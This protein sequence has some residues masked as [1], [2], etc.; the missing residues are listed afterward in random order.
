M[1]IRNFLFFFLIFISCSDQKATLPARLLTLER[2]QEIQEHIF[3]SGQSKIT[4]VYAEIKTTPTSEVL[5][6]NTIS[7]L[8]EHMKRVDSVT[9]EAVHALEKMKFG[10]LPVSIQ[11]KALIE[12]KSWRKEDKV[13]FTRIDLERINQE[14]EAFFLEKKQALDAKEL[15]KIMQD[16]QFQL[17]FQT[18]AYREYR[19]EK[20]FHFS[21]PK[22]P[23]VASKE[24]YVKQ[25]HAH[26]AQSSID[27]KED[28][29]CLTD[30]YVM[31][32]IPTWKMKSLS[33]EDWFEKQL[34]DLDALGEIQLLTNLQIQL[35]NAR[36]LAL[37]QIS[38]KLLI[39]G[40]GFDSI[41]PMV[42]GQA[43][44]KEGEKAEIQVRMGAFDSYQ[45]PEVQIR[46]NQ[47][48]EISYKNGVAFIRF[49][50]KKGEHTMKGML[51]IRNKAGDLK[52]EPWIWKYRVE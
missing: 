43:L 10:L 14:N 7:E 30:M 28:M 19:G 20:T 6:K 41:A 22:L 11:K 26:F 25:I 24:E 1:K 35:L 2:S 49:N 18:G 37:T 13:Y 48:L 50:P 46:D 52:S 40:Y 15:V 42:T 16:N 9:F 8:Y 47:P 39:C 33:A 21:K 36:R 5:F 27:K 12:V 23:L 51:R 17:T 4:D 45:N 3:Y 34:T 29:Q 32:A 44:Y 31:L 38:S